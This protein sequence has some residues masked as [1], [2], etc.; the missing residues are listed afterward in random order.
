MRNTS[1]LLLVVALVA[2]APSVQAGLVAQKAAGAVVLSDGTRLEGQVYLTPGKKLRVFDGQHKK[3]YRLGLAEISRVTCDVAGDTALDKWTWKEDTSDEKI[4]RGDEYHKRE[5]SLVV[6][7]RSGVT[8]HG[9]GSGVI[10]VES[11]GK[12]RRFI[13]KRNERYRPDKKPED[14]VYVKEIV[15]EAPEGADGGGQIVGAIPAAPL[16]TA[17][18]AIRADGMA[19]FD[20]TLDTPT[21]QYRIGNVP[22]GTYDLAVETDDKVYIGLSGT[23]GL[24]EKRMTGLRNH[25]DHVREFFDVRK[26]ALVAVR[27]RAVKVLVDS[28]RRRKT[29]LEN[30]KAVHRFDIYTMHEFEGD[31]IIDKRLF[32][33]RRMILKDE[34]V[35]PR[36]LIVEPRL[37]GLEVGDS[38]VEFD[39]GFLME[40]VQ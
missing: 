16:V 12:K 37:A 34:N 22:S 32:L 4:F 35:Q 13:L 10:Y 6:Y 36:E 2:C 23:M 29:S 38:P 27:G 20:A 30:M 18:K 17:I 25:L 15:L 9:Y 40:Q 26:P 7:L 3:W 24:D 28:V 11:E 39:L 8:V 1:G 14:I 33:S 31:W 21:L 5:Y 19:I